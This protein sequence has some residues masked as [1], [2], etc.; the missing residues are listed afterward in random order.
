MAKGEQPIEGVFRVEM[1]IRPVTVKG[2]FIRPERIDEVQARVFQVIERDLQPSE[3]VQG[4]SG[5]EQIGNWRVW[6]REEAAL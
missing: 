3:R 5:R 4:R 1:V 6:Y 2:T